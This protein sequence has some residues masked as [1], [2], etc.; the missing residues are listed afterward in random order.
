MAGSKKYSF[1]VNSRRFDPYRNFKFRSAVA[2]LAA[3][4][5]AGAA[6]FFLTRK[7]SA[8]RSAVKD[9]HE[10]YANP[11]ADPIFSVKDR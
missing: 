10:R 6:A 2:P 4:V 9:S 8:K 3:A 7:L 5:L 11:D 1:S